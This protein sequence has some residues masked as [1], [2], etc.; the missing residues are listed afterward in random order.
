MGGFGWRYSLIKGRLIA[1]ASQPCFCSV[2]KRIILKRKGKI[3]VV[4]GRPGPPPARAGR[5]SS[6]TPALILNSNQNIS[7]IQADLP[8]KQEACL[9]A[10]EEEDLSVEDLSKNEDA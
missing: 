7:N 6:P 4:P 9:K 10:H 1:A 3:G 2:D 8:W 5:K